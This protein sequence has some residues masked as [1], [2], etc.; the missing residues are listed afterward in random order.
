MDQNLGGVGRN[1]GSQNQQL[2]KMLFEKTGCIS[3]DSRLLAREVNFL[4]LLR[5]LFFLLGW[6]RLRAKLSLRLSSFPVIYP[7]F[8]LSHLLQDDKRCQSRGRRR[9]KGWE[10]MWSE[11]RSWRPGFPCVMAFSLVY[12]LRKGSVLNCY[13]LFYPLGGITKMTFRWRRLIFWSRDQKKG[14]QKDL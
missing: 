14:R 9:A 2:F 4:P 5:D 1:P 3:T 11:G 6:H 13:T 8:A 7:G 12:I 10:G